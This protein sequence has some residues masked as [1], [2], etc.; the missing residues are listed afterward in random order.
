MRRELRAWW[1]V[2]AWVG[3]I[4]VATSVPI[5]RGPWIRPEL[6]LDKLAHFGLYFGLGWVL[7][8]ALWWTERW[9]VM[10][11]SIAYL[12]GLAFAAVDEWHQRV[13]LSRQA[14]FSDWL[15]DAAGVS[16]GVALYVWHRWR[17]HR[18]PTEVPSADVLP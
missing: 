10:A 3:L 12:A 5:P 17:R 18:R 4:G 7:A 14:S 11:L 16:L 15:A 9:T 8:R 1:P 13:L 6:P 2:V